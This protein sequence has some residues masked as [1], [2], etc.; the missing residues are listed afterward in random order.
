[1]SELRISFLGGA[2]SI[3]ASC[4]LVQVAGTSLLMDAGVRFRREQALPDLDQLTG[5]KLDAIL[6][7]HAHSDHTG[8]LPVVHEAYPN[9]PIHMTPPTADLVGILQRDALKLMDMAL[10]REGDIPL[11][12]ERQV[13]GMLAAVRWVEHDVPFTVGEVE[14]TYLPASHIL[15]ASM[16]HLRTPVGNVL[17]TGDYSVSSQRTVPGL[18][19]PALPVDV[20]V[21]ESTYGNRLHADRKVAERKLVT[22]VAEVLAGGGRLLIPAFA[23]GRAQE[24]LLILQEAVR[25]GEIPKAPIWIDGMVRSVCGVYSQHEAYAAPALARAIKVTGKPF[26][27]EPLRPVKTA[28][29][30]TV[31]AS[32]PCV[33]VASSGMLAGGPSA[34]YAAELAPHKQDAIFITGYQ[35]EESPGRALLQ[36]AQ[37]QGPRSLRLRDRTVDVACSFE[38]YSLSAHADRMQMVGLAEALAPGTVVLVHG[39][40]DAK[41]GLA[42]SLRAK[43]IVLADEGT[44]VV[45]AYKRRLPVRAPHSA[46]ELSAPPKD[47]PTLTAEAAEALV[48][49]AT[50]RPLQLGALV[51][52][53][54]GRRVDGATREAFAAEL[55]ATGKA[56]RDADNAELVWPLTSPAPGPPPP[57]VEEALAEELKVGNPKGRLLEYLMRCGAPPP[58]WKASARAKRHVVELVIDV[59]GA[60][61]MSGPQEASTLKLAEQLAAREVL[62][63]LAIAEDGADVVAVDEQQATELK[64]RNPKGHLLEVCA[65]LKVLPPRFEVVAT[66]AGFAAIAEVSAAGTSRRSRRY[67]ALDAR[68]AEQA[69]AA[70]LLDV[71][72]QVTASAPTTPAPSLAPAGGTTDLRG[73]LNELRQLG[74]IAD[75]GY[76]VLE[77]RGPSHQPIFVM[78]GWW[79]PAAAGEERRHTAAIE[80]RSKKDGEREAAARLYEALRETR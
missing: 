34:F 61:V 68:T 66:L 59:A 74:V 62:A 1:M 38:T 77:Q 7:T 56:R 29:R 18:E 40:P 80:A 32:S 20:L 19:R 44:Q 60:R 4:A 72:A 10:E 21:T 45:R 71:M 76:E 75:F 35:D 58:E 16:I 6:V 25:K 14:V 50:G 41:R 23:I 55:V 52:A 13:E 12:S 53:W 47:M 42:A 17:F 28:Q 43:D 33:I 48:G 24:V 37:E 8:A 39:D 65:Q 15:G 27:S 78:R 11:Y 54:Y 69:A 49:P 51:K 36:L 57:D 22:R 73:R 2:S 9:T 3:G 63:K 26:S 70:E 79:L 64:A 67:Q 30:K 5:K 31:L 46:D